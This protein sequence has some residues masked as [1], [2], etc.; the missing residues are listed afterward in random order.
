[1]STPDIR[2][3]LRLIKP[4]AFYLFVN[5]DLEALPAGQ[6]ALLRM[7]PMNAQRVK[8]KLREIRT[9]LIE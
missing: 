7:G 5:P 8:A 9:A 6:K 3:P 2:E 4:E 1:L